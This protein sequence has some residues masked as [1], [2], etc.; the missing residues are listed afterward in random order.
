MLFHQEVVSSNLTAPTIFSKLPE[1]KPSHPR[2]MS[3][4]PAQDIV[5][6][7]VLTGSHQQVHFPIR[8]GRPHHDSAVKRIVAIWLKDQAV[9]S[10]RGNGG[11]FVKSIF[12]DTIVV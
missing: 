12:T 4:V 8:P 9:F 3:S 1:L 7:L 5:L 11:R 6:V 10:S 2:R